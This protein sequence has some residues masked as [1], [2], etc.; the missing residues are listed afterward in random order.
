[1]TDAIK[2]IDADDSAAAKEEMIKEG[3]QPTTLNELI[4]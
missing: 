4:E 2:G 1:M 3:A